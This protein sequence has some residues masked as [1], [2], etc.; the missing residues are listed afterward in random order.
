MSHDDDHQGRN[1]AQLA[2]HAQ[3][4][5]S[6]FARFLAS[7]SPK[8]RAETRERM[9]KGQAWIAKNEGKEGGSE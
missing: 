9:T 6:A 1:D 8:E 2:R 3:K 7:L 4:S 5:P